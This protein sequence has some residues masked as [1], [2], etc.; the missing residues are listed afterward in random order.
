MD[1]PV[2]AE[3][4][5]CENLRL[6]IRELWL[7]VRA[8]EDLDITVGEVYQR[9]CKVENLAVAAERRYRISRHARGDRSGVECVGRSH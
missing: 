9:L 8:L 1:L 5:E 4:T 2:W 6:E 7:R 3:L